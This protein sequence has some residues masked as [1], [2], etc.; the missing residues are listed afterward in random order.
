M[1]QPLPLL[2]RW[3]VSWPILQLCWIL[4]FGMVTFLSLPADARH[5]GRR[6]RVVDPTGT[7]LNIRD[8]DGDIVCQV[9]NGS[10]L[11]GSVIWDTVGPRHSKNVVGVRSP[12]VLLANGDECLGYA[13]RPYLQEIK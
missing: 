4:S 5:E 8:T 12:S 9:P 3:L 2:R 11:I 1:A 10:L 13:Y 7:P 6:F